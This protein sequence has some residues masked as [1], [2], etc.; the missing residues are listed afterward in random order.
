MD[1]RAIRKYARKGRNTIEGWFARVDAEIYRCILLLQGNVGLSGSLAEIGVHHG[2]SFMMLCFSLEESE[3]A[4]CIDLFSQQALNIDR[5]GCGDRSIFEENLK[6]FKINTE[7]IKIIESSSADVSA[8]AIVA[9]AG[10]IRFFSIDGGH[11]TDI[12]VNDLSIAEGCIADHGIIALDDFHRPDWPEVSVGFTKWYEKYRTK[13]VPFLIGFN[14]LYLC[15]GQYIGI[16]K[17][18]IYIDP[19]LCHFIDKTAMLLGEKVPVLSKFFLPEA[20]T[21]WTRDAILRVYAPGMFSV[22]RSF[23]GGGGRSK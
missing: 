8:S 19:F 4:V 13:V 18:S 7:N 16:Y 20:G 17:K 15:T 2:K 12:V 11:S 9:L 5:S 6:K 14:K 1:E 21:R 23:A 22:L 3:K 10:P